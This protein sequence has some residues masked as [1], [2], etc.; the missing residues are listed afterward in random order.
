LFDFLPSGIDWN[1][2]E[3]DGGSGTL[4]VTFTDK[5]NTSHEP[6]GQVS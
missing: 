6:L 4:G 2:G 3:E 5:D 1:R